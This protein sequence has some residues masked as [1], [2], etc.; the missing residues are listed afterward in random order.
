MHELFSKAKAEILAI[1][2]HFLSKQKQKKPTQNNQEKQ[3][4]KPR[5]KSLLQHRMKKCLLLF[6]S[7][8]YFLYQAEGGH[9]MGF[10]T[11]MQFWRIF[12]LIN[13]QG[14]NLCQYKSYGKYCSCRQKRDQ[15]CLCTQALY[16]RRYFRGLYT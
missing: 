10:S 1:I 6:R 9:G 15:F 3:S 5:V 2:P 14:E 12:I 11:W 13:T 4:K 8:V 16:I 7:R